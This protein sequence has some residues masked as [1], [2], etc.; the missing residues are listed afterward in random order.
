MSKE[1]SYLSQNNILRCPYFGL[2]DDVRTQSDFP[3]EVNCCHRCK[4]P[5]SPSYAHQQEFCLTK[6]YS[7]CIMLKDTRLKSLPADVRMSEVPTTN[8]NKTLLTVSYTHLRAHE[9]PEHLVCRLLLEKKKK[10]QKHT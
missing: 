1:D 2:I 9:T 7:S 5:E 4:K 8:R 6:Q 10:K 3:S